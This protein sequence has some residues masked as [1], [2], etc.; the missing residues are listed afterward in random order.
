MT[1][2][3]V[4][5][6]VEMVQSNGCYPGDPQLLSISEYD[7]V[8]FGKICYHYAYTIGEVYS[9]LESPA[10]GAVRVI[11]RR[12]GGITVFGRAWLN[13]QLSKAQR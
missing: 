4:D 3:S 2:E 8:T 13:E 11:W 5:V 1:I 9:L 7:N 6:V 12:N 10:V